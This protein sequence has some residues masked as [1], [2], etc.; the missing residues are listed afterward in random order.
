MPWSKYRAEFTL[1]ETIQFAYR[2]RGLGN[3]F[4]VGTRGLDTGN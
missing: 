2:I 4:V 1:E 3:S